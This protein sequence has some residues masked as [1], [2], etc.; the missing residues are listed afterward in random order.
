[1][2]ETIP[3]VPAVRMSLTGQDPTI[4]PVNLMKSEA[5]EDPGAIVAWAYQCLNTP[6]NLPLA[7]RE[8]HFSLTLRAFKEPS[9]STLSAAEWELLTHKT[10]R[11]RNRIHRASSTPHES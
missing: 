5:A 10:L 2:L 8:L 4:D 6:A 9:D 11:L 7:A 3:I 1:M